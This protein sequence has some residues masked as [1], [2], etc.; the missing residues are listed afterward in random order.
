MQIV[1]VTTS[2]NYAAYYWYITRCLHAVEWCVTALAWPV[3]I[4]RRAMRV[5][6]A[7]INPTC[8]LRHCST[9]HAN[10]SPQQL[11]VFQGPLCF[12]S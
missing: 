12:L 9:F 4:L 5:R 2:G 10:T 7:Y 1:V 8:V 6:G 11:L 3:D